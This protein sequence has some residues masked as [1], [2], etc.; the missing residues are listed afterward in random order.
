MLANRNYPREASFSLCRLWHAFKRAFFPLLTPLIIIGGIVT[1]AFTPTESAVACSLFLG[2]VVYRT[3]S[4]RHILRVSTDTIETSAAIL[5]IVA[6]AAIFA[7]ILTANQVAVILE[8]LML[9]ISENRYVILLIIM[10]VVLVIGLFMETIATITILVP[11]LL[12]IAAKVGIDPVHL[13]I[14][15]VDVGRTARGESGTM[16]LQKPD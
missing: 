15:H 16:L 9:N 4:Y 8:D 2:L 10:A 3:L 1:G 7:W 13:G 6:A 14:M 12:P 11:V 5:M